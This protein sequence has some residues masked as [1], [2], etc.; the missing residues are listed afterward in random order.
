MEASLD[1]AQLEDSHYGDLSTVA[2]S[3]P[4]DS[5]SHIRLPFRTTTVQTHPG[6]PGPGT[7]QLDTDHVGMASQHP[8]PHYPDHDG[9]KQNRNLSQHP[10]L[11]QV[12]RSISF[13][14]EP[15][16]ASHSVLHTT[17]ELGQYSL[18]A[19]PHEPCNAPPTTTG[20]PTVLP[21]SQESG[22]VKGQ[23]V[24]SLEQSAHEFRYRNPHSEGK[25]LNSN[26]ATTQNSDSVNPL[27]SVPKHDSATVSGE[28]LGV[29]HVQSLIA[30]QRTPGIGKTLGVAVSKGAHLPVEIRKKMEVEE[31]QRK[32]RENKRKELA[33]KRAR[34]ASSRRG[35]KRV[36]LTQD[37]SFIAQPMHV[38]S[39]HS[40]L[41]A[42]ASFP[43]STNMGNGFPVSSTIPIVEGSENMHMSPP[44]VSPGGT[45]AVSVSISEPISAPI[46]LQ[47]H[48]PL[49]GAFN[50]SSL[51]IPSSVAVPVVPALP[52]RPGPGSGYGTGNDSDAGINALALNSS[53]Q[54]LSAGSSER[55]QQQSTI[56]PTTV[57]IT[58]PDDGDISVYTTAPQGTTSSTLTAATNPAASGGPSASGAIMKSGPRQIEET[59]GT[60]K[61]FTDPQSERRNMGSISETKDHLRIQTTDTAA[62]EDEL[63]SPKEGESDKHIQSIELEDCSKRDMRLEPVERVNNTIVTDEAE[64]GLSEQDCGTGRTRQV[65]EQ[66]K[67]TEET[68][69]KEYEDPRD[70]FHEDGEE[71]L[72]HSVTW[73]SLASIE[74]P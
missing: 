59:R 7:S 25:E 23:I 35:R 56:A 45:G 47:G 66:G 5:N 27:L 21:I 43:T 31:A 52:A 10:S 49:S 58:G 12:P 20:I 41:H 50:H 14:Q 36:K 70:T 61:V 1:G 4:Q 6:T 33:M 30:V 9:Q 38:M 22:D 3:L 68:C 57:D 40:S 55:V 39:S 71:D 44:V 65:D 64:N 53:N 46:S 13:S 32:W 60:E 54:F 67:R 37:E 19:P 72:I 74:N 51:P 28:E 15:H 11:P 62:C 17:R 69:G 63:H 42:G 24:K 16:V 2:V 48:V 26:I 34:S 29:T 18:T 8:S 73:Q